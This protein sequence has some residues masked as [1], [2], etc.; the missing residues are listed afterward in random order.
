MKKPIFLIIN[1][2]CLILS[3]LSIISS[4]IT[5]QFGPDEFVLINDGYGGFYADLDLAD[6]FSRDHDKVGDINGDGIIDLVVGARSDDD[7]IT[8]AG[9]VYILFMNNNGTVQSHQKI[10]MLEGGFSETLLEG[11]YFGYGVAGIGDYDGDD[12]PDIAVSAPTPPNRAL[13]IVHLNQDGTVK[14]FVKNEGIIGQGLSAIGDINNDGRVDLAACNPNSND[15]GS[16][17]GAISILFFNSNSQIIPENTV[18]I[19]STQGG[20]G[21]GLNNGDQFGGREA[22]FLGDMDGDGNLELAVGAFRSDNGKGA[23]WVL[24]LDPNTFH[25]ESKIRIAQNESGFNEILPED[26]NFGHAMC[27]AGDLN[28]D[29]IIDI[30]TGAN[31]FNEGCGYILYLNSDKTVKTFSRINNDEGGFGLSLE[32]NERFSRSVSYIGN[33][34]EDGNIA[35]NIGGGAGGTGTLYIL[36]FKPC[37]FS[38]Q[39]G[40]NYWSGGTTLFSNWNHNSQTVSGEPL[41]IEQCRTN[42]FEF[43]A[44]HLTYNENDGRCICKDSTA[45]LTSSVEGSTAYIRDCS[46]SEILGDLNFDGIVNILDVVSLVNIVLDGENENPAGDMNGDE[47]YNVLDVVLLINI[48][49]S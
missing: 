45:I 29:G 6:R 36:F 27:A 15:G 9:A 23:I 1:K 20:F 11:N 5:T 21:E 31:Q 47:L 13:Y 43:D 12:I 2:F 25:V 49:L 16:Q 28:D 14:D 26:A 18:F 38:L 8:D 33:L 19:S 32:Q 10:S 24:S 7:G 41:S 35:V 44:I 42:S 48:I 17:R 46:N 4:Q 22:A 3:F 34:S 37:N 40:N 39:D 30:I